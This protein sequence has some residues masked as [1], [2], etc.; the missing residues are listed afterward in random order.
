MAPSF[1]ASPLCTWLVVACMSLDCQIDRS[2]SPY[3]FQYY[4]KMNRCSRRRKLLSK[5]ATATSQL[6]RGVI[7]S[8]Y[9]SIIQGLMSSCLAFEP[10]DEYYI[11]NTLSSLGFFGE[12][13][14]S[15][16]FG[17]KIGNSNRRQRLRRW[18]SDNS[19]RD[20]VVPKGF[21]RVYVGPK[22]QRFVIKIELANHPLFQI[23][24]EDAANEYGLRN[25]GPICLPCDVHF[26]C[27]ALAKM[28]SAL[29]YTPSSMTT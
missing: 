9:G 16:L 12:S 26:F 24:L 10:C 1:M 3:A 11:S 2:R 29:F 7:S 23:L 14:F 4:R 17:C 8:F 6:N 5:C 13:G 15:S 20:K 22:K 28:E 19:K 18:L 25:D 27:Q 21:F